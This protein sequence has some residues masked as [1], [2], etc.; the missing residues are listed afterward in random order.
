MRSFLYKATTYSLLIGFML[1]IM[2]LIKW[3][4]IYGFFGFALLACVC[5]VVAGRMERK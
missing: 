3:Q 5:D 4:F 2:A 1:L